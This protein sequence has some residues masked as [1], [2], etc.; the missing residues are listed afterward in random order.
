[1][2]DSDRPTIGQPAVSERARDGVQNLGNGYSAKMNVN[3][4]FESSLVDV[5]DSNS[6]PLLLAENEESVNHVSVTDFENRNLA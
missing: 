6:D 3:F 5:V 1:V 4:L 2:R